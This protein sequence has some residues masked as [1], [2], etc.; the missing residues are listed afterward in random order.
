MQV[1]VTI[2]LRHIESSPA[3]EARIHAKVQKIAQLFQSIISCKVVVEEKHHHKHNG[4]IFAVHITLSIPGENIYITR[5][6]EKNHA[7]ED[8]YVALRDAF[9]A[10]RNQLVARVDKMKRKVKHHDVPPH[11]KVTAVDPE[12]GYGWIE[13][14]DGRDIYFHEN[15]VINANLETLHAGDEVRLHV[16]QGEQGPQASSLHIVGKH[17][18]V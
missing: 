10:L 11:G 18:P 15:S 12:S 16:E 9:D 4:N 13:T 6:A 2:T 7:H 14:D 8:V 17:H 1:P 3:L 5:E